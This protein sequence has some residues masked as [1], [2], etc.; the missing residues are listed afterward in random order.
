MI[1]K[2]KALLKEGLEVEG[3]KLD[4]LS[5]LESLGVVLSKSWAV[6]LSMHS[7]L[8]EI[9]MFKKSKEKVISNFKNILA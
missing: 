7:V 5:F 6:V 4:G 3:L 1:V 2:P 9:K 8:G